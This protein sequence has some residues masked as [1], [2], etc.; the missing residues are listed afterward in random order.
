MICT[1]KEGNAATCVFC[2]RISS[3][4]VSDQKKGVDRLPWSPALQFHFHIEIVPYEQIVHRS[5]HRDLVSLVSFTESQLRGRGREAAA[6]CAIHLLPLALL[7]AAW[8]QGMKS[9]S[10]MH[11]TAGSDL[12]VDGTNSTMDHPRIRPSDGWIGHC[13]GEGVECQIGTPR[14]M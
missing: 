1:R 6:C 3:S 9:S 12:T 10:C 2:L 8:T 4:T 5:R 13:S 14:F 11:M 7:V